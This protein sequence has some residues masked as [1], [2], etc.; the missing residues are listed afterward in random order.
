MCK[1]D[2][3]DPTTNTNIIS[4]IREGDPFSTLSL[5]HIA[6][7]STVLSHLC[8]NV[9]LRNEIFNRTSVL[10]S[11]FNDIV[12]NIYTSYSNT[13]NRIWCYETMNSLPI[14]HMKAEKF[15]PPG[16]ILYMTPTVDDNS[17]SI[18][19]LFGSNNNDKVTIRDV[20]RY[21]FSDLILHTRM[22][23]IS[24]HLP[25]LYESSLRQLLVDNS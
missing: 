22:L 9:T 13:E 17:S 20:S 3:T 10:S 24:R 6:D 7:L 12:Q 2:N 19:V 1:P 16:R 14:T 18:S 8:V 4:V 15:Y 21:E 23:D 25:N 5:G 11:S